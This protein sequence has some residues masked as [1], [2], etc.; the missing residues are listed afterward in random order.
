MEEAA[1]FGKE[2]VLA[3]GRA[4]SAASDEARDPFGAW[5]ARLAAASAGSELAALVDEALAEKDGA[6]RSWRLRLL[7]AR[8]AEIDPAGGVVF[9]LEKDAENAPPC[10]WIL[11][12]WAVRDVEAALAFVTAEGA[13]PT[14]ADS[15]VLSRV[16]EELIREN[17]AAFWAWFQ[18]LGKKL[19]W[20]SPGTPLAWEA[21]KELGRA[22]SREMEAMALEWA[23][24][25]EA[26]ASGWNSGAASLFK[27][28][29]EVRAEGDPAAALAWAQTVPKKY[30]DV[31]WAAALPVLARSD[32]QAALRQLNAKFQEPR[33]MDFFYDGRAAQVIGPIV[34]EIGRRDL[35]EAVAWVAGLHDQSYGGL[36]AVKQLL[37]QA[38]REGRLGY[39][40]AFAMAGESGVPFASSQAQM[41]ASVWDELPREDLGK[42]AAWLLRQQ[43]GEMRSR[44]L[45]QVVERWARADDASAV[46]F[47]QALENTGER[48]TLYGRILL[49][50][51]FSSPRVVKL[52]ALI[53]AEDRAA[54][55]AQGLAPQY[56]ERMLPHE[57]PF[58]SL[59]AE[60]ARTP[61]GEDRAKASRALYQI[62]GAQAPEDALAHAAVQADAVMQTDG[63]MGAVEGWAKY[64][65][66]SAS[67]WLAEQPPGV[68]RDA[69]A[70]QL[71][72]SLSAA[73]PDSAWAWAAD[74]GDPATRQEARAGVLRHWR[75]ADPAS[76]AAAVESTKTL[77]PAERQ[78]LAAILAGQDR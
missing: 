60:L 55:L 48:R 30:R 4:H 54:A 63:V 64:D 59:G 66:W 50:E 43:A 28:L 57:A 34:R 14:A 35:R 68:A 12:E 53:P 49:D 18:R 6:E 2:S 61:P 74:I 44:A 7:C 10:I 73:E 13:N 3:A 65:A 36:Y 9:F 72:R 42:A 5:A 22:R 52:A 46:A 24:E 21:W 33:G 29:A 70:H 31:C 11:A 56:E 41:L 16:G 58:A 38:V 69:A 78:K 1:S 27:L 17:P 8:W 20:Q 67:Q 45:G 26:D 71:S 32:P 40:E 39:Q 51:G 62:W 77:A 25:A 75:E 47:V 19:S 37:G 76:A 15:S 23:A